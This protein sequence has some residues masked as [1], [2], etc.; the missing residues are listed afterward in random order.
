M[1][2]QISKQVEGTDPVHCLEKY[3]FNY[4]PY[5]IMSIA[6]HN[7]SLDPCVLLNTSRNHVHDLFFFIVP[8]PKCLHEDIIVCILYARGE[9]CTTIMIIKICVVDNN[10]RL[11]KFSPSD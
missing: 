3:N 1:G 2:L 4:I 6:I 5:T 9:D 10:D 8:N 7:P 11:T